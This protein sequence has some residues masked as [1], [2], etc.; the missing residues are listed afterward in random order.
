MREAGINTVVLEQ[1]AV[2]SYQLLGIEMTALDIRPPTCIKDSESNC[3]SLLALILYL[4]KPQN[5]MQQSR[6]DLQ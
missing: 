2:D 4:E 3:R 1:K 6:S 5:S